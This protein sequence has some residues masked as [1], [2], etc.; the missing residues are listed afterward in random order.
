MVGGQEVNGRQWRVGD[1]YTMG[2]IRL[3]TL[4]PP[5]DLVTASRA[6]YYLYNGL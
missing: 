3:Q 4:L 2:G 6:S 1:E 5:P